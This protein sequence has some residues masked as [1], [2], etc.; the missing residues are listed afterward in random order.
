LATI[1]EVVDPLNYELK[2]AL[3][4]EIIKRVGSQLDI[5][6]SLLIPEKYVENYIQIIQAYAH[7]KHMLNNI[8]TRL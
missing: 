7:S 5:D 4:T 3:V 2:K 1:N 8:F 6:K